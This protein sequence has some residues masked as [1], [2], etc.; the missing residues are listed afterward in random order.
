[1]VGL[2]LIHAV[3]LDID[4]RVTPV[5]SAAQGENREAVETGVDVEAV[6]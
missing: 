6:E 4:R 5:H 1:V 3:G 2:V